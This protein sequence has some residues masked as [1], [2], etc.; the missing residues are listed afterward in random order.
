MEICKWE[1]KTHDTKSIGNTH[2]Q[3]FIIHCGKRYTKSDGSPDGELWRTFAQL[4]NPLVLRAALIQHW[5]T[6]PLPLDP[7]LVEVSIKHHSSPLTKG[8]A[9]EPC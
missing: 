7:V 1:L 9:W 8:W 2:T 3:L 5:V 4:H 6:R